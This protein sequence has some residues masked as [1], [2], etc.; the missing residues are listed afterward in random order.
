MLQ[1]FD[2]VEQQVGTL[3]AAQDPQIG[4]DEGIGRDTQRLPSFEV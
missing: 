2:A 4:D 1:Q 3:V